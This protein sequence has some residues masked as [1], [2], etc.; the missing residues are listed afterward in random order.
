MVLIFINFK[1]NFEVHNLS[2][3]IRSDTTFEIF[4]KKNDFINK[5]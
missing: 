1:L 5:I 2:Y 3:T 4:R